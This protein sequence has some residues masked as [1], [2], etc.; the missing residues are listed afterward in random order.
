MTSSD[1]SARLRAE[2]DSLESVAASPAAA[3]REAADRIE[4][5]E[6][7]RVTWLA[8]ERAVRSMRVYPGL[9]VDLAMQEV[10]DD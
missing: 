9:A 2:A 6:A 7:E 5:L 3:L 4:E 10:P 8:L 1:L